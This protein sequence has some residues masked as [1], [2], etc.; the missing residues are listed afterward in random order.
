VSLLCA[1]EAEPLPHHLVPLLDIWPQN[2]DKSIALGS[3]VVVA[4]GAVVEVVV[5]SAPITL[6]WGCIISQSTFHGAYAP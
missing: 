1:E 5:V 4:V 2:A 3:G 6:L